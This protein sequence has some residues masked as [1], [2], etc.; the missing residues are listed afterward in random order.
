VRAAAL[1]PSYTISW[2]VTYDRSIEFSERALR[3]SPRDPM[4]VMP[5]AGQAGA[6]LMK[7][8]YARAV[9]HAKR[10]LQIYPSHTPSFLI[11]IASLMRLGQTDQAREIAGRLLSA[12]PD[13]RVVAKAPVLEH[14]VRELRDAGLP[15]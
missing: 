11:A 6:W 14:F 4:S 1:P 5:L 10:A 3:L 9:A 15:G 2:D 12:S 8:D 13:Y 7:G